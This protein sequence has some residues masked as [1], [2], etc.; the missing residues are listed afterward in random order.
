MVLL[1]PFR[2]N[3]PYP[4]VCM[5]QMF[6][7]IFQS[8]SYLFYV[9]TGISMVSFT[10]PFLAEQTLQRLENPFPSHSSILYWRSTL[11]WN[12]T[13]RILLLLGSYGMVLTRWFSMWQKQVLRIFVRWGRQVHCW[14]DASGFHSFFRSL[15]CYIIY[16]FALGFGRVF[17]SFRPSDALRW[18]LRIPTV[19]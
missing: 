1:I 3:S 19:Q 14:K 15:R 4:L 12:G 6:G 13:H 9:V 7:S 8:R 10:P 18:N 5:A 17:Q 16:V 11:P 2:V